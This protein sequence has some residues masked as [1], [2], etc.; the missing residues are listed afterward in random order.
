MIVMR[1]E[2]KIYNVWLTPFACLSLPFIALVVLILAVSDLLG[3]NEVISDI[4]LVWIVGLIIF[5]IGSYSASVICSRALCYADDVEDVIISEKK[6]E[7]AVRYLSIMLLALNFIGFYKALNASGGI[8]FIASDTFQDNYGYGWIAHVRSISVPLLVYQI[9]T[10]RRNQFVNII[11]VVL[12]MLL[13]L[14]YQVKGWMLLPVMSGLIYR[15]LIRRM[16][17]TVANITTFIIF[18]VVVFCSAYFIGYLVKN[19]SAVFVENN[20]VTL[21]KSFAFYCFAGVLGFSAAMSEGGNLCV[22]H[23]NLLVSPFYNMYS[24]L[25]FKKTVSYVTQYFH[26]VGN[27]YKS[28]VHTF[29]G[30]IYLFSSNTFAIFFTLML[31]MLVYVMYIYS[32]R[33]SNCWLYIVTSFFMAGLSLGWFEYYFW[34]LSFVELPIAAIAYSSIINRY[35]RTNEI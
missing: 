17:V 3:Y 10:L 28:N 22:D 16:V 19:S 24:V 35:G 30:T 21:L 1:I 13:I 11:I 9:G 26:F 5:T 32:Y 2:S 34:N 14:A 27:D 31:S 25:T 18:S 4:I 6:A 33:K 20:Y 12:F 23:T 7:K 29:F 8:M 15:I